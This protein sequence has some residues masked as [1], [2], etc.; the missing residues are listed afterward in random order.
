MKIVESTDSFLQTVYRIQ[1]GIATIAV[2][3]TKRDAEVAKA[4]LEKDREE[5]K[6][7]TLMSF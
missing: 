1:D 2:C 3:Y 7:E 4:A 6:K 5:R